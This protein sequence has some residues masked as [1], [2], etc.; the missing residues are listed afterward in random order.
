MLMQLIHDSL[1]VELRM[2]Y[3]ASY[4]ASPFFYPQR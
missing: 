1:L 3:N 2:T 4:G